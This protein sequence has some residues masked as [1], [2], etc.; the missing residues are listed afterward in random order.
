MPRYYVSF[1]HPGRSGLGFSVASVDVTTEEPINTVGDLNA[2]YG[3]LAQQGFRNNVK[4]L[5]FSLYGDP[6]PSP[7]QATPAPA[8]LASRPARP[9]PPHRPGRHS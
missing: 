4:I 1:S 3:Q 5:A 8:S 2:V 7:Q 6:Q 9:R